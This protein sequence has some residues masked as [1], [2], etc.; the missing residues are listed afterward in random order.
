MATEGARANKLNIVQTDAPDKR[1]D[2]YVNLYKL[3]QAK[4]CPAQQ[5]HDF[6]DYNMTR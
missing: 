4:V 5:M 6:S 1:T 3:I 2:K